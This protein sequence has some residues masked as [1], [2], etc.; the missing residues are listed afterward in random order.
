MT[1]KMI[2]YLLEVLM[3]EEWHG[4]YTEI[5]ATV[6]WFDTMAD[7][8]EAIK[9]HVD[10]RYGFSEFDKT[11]RQRVITYDSGDIDI[12]SVFKRDMSEDE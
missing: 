2:S 8:R 9:T 7:V 6:G 5:K 1:M 12:F 4:G 11:R 3:C 10:G